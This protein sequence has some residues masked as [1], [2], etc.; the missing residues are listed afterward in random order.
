MA[1]GSAIVGKIANS[2][3]NLTFRRTKGQQVISAKISQVE[4]ALTLAQ[5][6]HR[7]RVKYANLFRQWVG[8]EYLGYFER[9]N[10]R[11]STVNKFLGL[12]IDYAFFVGKDISSPLADITEG[13]SLYN[14]G[15]PS[16]NFLPVSM[17][18]AVGY[19]TDLKPYDYTL[20]YWMPAKEGRGCKFYFIWGEE[21]EHLGELGLATGYSSTVLDSISSSSSDTDL[22]SAI[23]SYYDLGSG[24]TVT[25]L[26]AVGEGQWETIDDNSLYML[27]KL[28]PPAHITY[29]IGANYVATRSDVSPLLSGSL[30]TSVS[31]SSSEG[32]NYKM[33]YITFDAL[34][35][36]TAMSDYTNTTRVAIGGT[37]LVY[38]SNKVQNHHVMSSEWY[39]IYRKSGKYPLRVTNWF[40]QTPY[41]IDDVTKSIATDYGWT[42]KGEDILNPESV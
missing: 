10:K 12:A 22:I 9:L 14:E 36:N 11:E 31:S 27:N 26:V 5:I 30:A 3:G 18:S 21:N 28:L 29:T 16:P 39:T 6:K 42:V 32:D 19:Y 20:E 7:A 33:A 35:N 17:P 41:W 2:A 1:K 15:Y 13:D 25:I 8:D 40:G 34:D 38:N 23:A 4:D 24:S 37:V